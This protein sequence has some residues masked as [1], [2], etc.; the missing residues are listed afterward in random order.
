M[1]L[2]RSKHLSLVTK[3]ELRRHTL[4][5]KSQWRGDDDKRRE[6]TTDD[7]SDANTTPT[8]KTPTINGNPSLRI[9]E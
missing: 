4:K 7:A 8:P 6:T 2:T 5:H 1:I 9:R 3:T